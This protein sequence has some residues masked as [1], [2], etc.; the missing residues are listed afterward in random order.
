[1]KDR[2]FLKSNN[3]LMGLIKEL[4][5]AGKGT[6][7]NKDLQKLQSSG[8]FSVDTP[9]TLQNK[10]LF[11]IMTHFGR[12]GREGLRSLGK[13]SFK[14]ATD[15][16]GH[17]YVAMAY[18]EADKIHHG[19]DSKK[20]S[21]KHQECMKPINSFV[22]S[23]PLKKYLSKLNPDNEALFQKPLSKYHKDGAV[24][25]GKTP[26]GVNQLYEFMPRLSAEAGLSKRYTNHCIRA[27]V[28]TNLCDAGVSNIGIM[29]V[30]G[31][32]N[33]QSLNTYIK[34][35]DSE[36]RAISSI[37]TGA[38]R[39][40]TLSAIQPSHSRYLPLLASA[41]QPCPTHPRPEIDHHHLSQF[42]SQNQTKNS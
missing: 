27:M 32:R 23:N 16:D 22:L 26:I 10:V 5:R 29:S 11:D 14:V 42:N 25:Y 39:E 30:T 3:V 21:L 41:S 15:N 6:S 36:R 9:N 2:T 31:H 37:L 38:N 8:L 34:P 33:V 13:K 19:V 12:R 40:S 24:W 28:A 35:A 17:R 20:K 18:N 4:K 1:M 7:E